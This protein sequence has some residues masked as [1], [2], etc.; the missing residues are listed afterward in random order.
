MLDRVKSMFSPLPEAAEIPETPLT[1]ERIALGRML[2]YDTRLSKNHDMSCNTCH[3]L[4]HYG[5]DIREENGKRNKTSLGHKKQLGERNSPTVYNAAFHA[6]QFWDGRAATVEE[7]AKGPILNPVEM[8][9]ADE[10]TVLTVLRSIPGYEALFKSAFPDDAEP[11]TYDNIANAIGAFERKL[12]TPA[13][14]DDFLSGKMTALTSQELHGLQVFLDV[15]CVTCHNGVGLGGTQFQKL[16]SVKPWP[17]LKDEGRYQVT[18]AEPD[19]YMF[20]VPSL[21]NITQTGPYLHD[22]SIES[23]E[24]MVKMMAE[25]QTARG[26]IS[27]EETSAIMAFLGALEGPIPTEYIKAPELPESGPDTPKPDP[28]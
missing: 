11:V 16:G 7:Q 4:D 20:K 9:M 28:N 21:R 23:L 10:P 12:V 15:G 3:D 8:A 5:V 22:G 25:Y 1:E 17:D 6:F 2:Y 26:T 24:Q 27:D 14:F 19:K 13:R 18:Q